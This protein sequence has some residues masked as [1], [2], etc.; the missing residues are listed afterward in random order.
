[1]V[2]EAAPILLPL[3]LVPTDNAAV[4]AVPPKRRWY[5]FSLRTLMIVVTLLAVLCAYVGWQAKIVRDRNLMLQWI[6]DHDGYCLIA[7]N[8][9]PIRAENPS[10]L[11]RWL[12][13]S[14]VAEVWFRSLVAR[15]DAA[16]IRET[17][18]GV[19][20]RYTGL[21]DSIMK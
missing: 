4:E 5:Q 20:L 10:L 17:F 14:Q 12:G 19:Q 1:V 9:L 8:E 16:R 15:D 18:P 6:K 3:R 13:D 11:R 7:T 2:S 21:P